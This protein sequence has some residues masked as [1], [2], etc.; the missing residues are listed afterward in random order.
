[1]SLDGKVA[2]VTGAARG[3]GAAIATRLAAD[4]ARV[5]VC[6][7][8]EV[9]AKAT[10][11]EL[12]GAIGVAVDVGDDDAVARCVEAVVQALGP[13]DILVN[14]AGIDR[15]QKFVDSESSTWDALLR[16]NLRGP[17]AMCHRV[18]PSMIERQSG[19]IVNI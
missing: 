9:A 12:P 10:A 14:N 8:D 19:R 11:A 13:I 6:D 15:I 4:G 7:L 1:M 2:L 5:A 3:I 16:V 17:V 18:V